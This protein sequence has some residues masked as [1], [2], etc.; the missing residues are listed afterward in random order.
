M[1][2][3]GKVTHLEGGTATIRYSNGTYVSESG[4]LYMVGDKVSVVEEA[5]KVKFVVNHSREV[6]DKGGQDVSS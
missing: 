2:Y 3:R 5:G 6:V 4:H 1:W